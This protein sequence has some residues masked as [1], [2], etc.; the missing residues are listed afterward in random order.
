MNT[1]NDALDSAT[2]GLTTEDDLEVST[3]EESSKEEQTDEVESTEEESS[4]ESQNEDESTEE[5]KK[6]EETEE[7]ET[8]DEDKESFTKVNPNDLPDEVKPV[9]KS[10]LADYTRKRQQE[11]EVVKTVQA[12][13]EQLKQQLSQLQGQGGGT[14]APGQVQID[15]TP[16]QI[17]EMTLPEYTQYVINK[18]LEVNQST[19]A[20]REVQN[21]EQEAV[22]GFLSMDARLNPEAE[23]SYDPRFA[24]YVGNAVDQDYEAHIAKTGSPVGFDYKGSA[25]KHIKSWDDWVN[26]IKKETVK[27]TSKASKQKATKL[28]KSAPPTTQAKSKTSSS[29]DLGGA[30]GAA[31]DEVAG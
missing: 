6:D 22:T 4:E 19:Q 25:E 8:K 14:K 2:D 1:L 30:I 18:A 20:T 9:Y 12:E 10:L 21:F 29:M 13:N 26:G 11:A 28:K 23:S 24:S 5:S 27:S 15:L 17:G 31:F 7:E 3:E 16:E